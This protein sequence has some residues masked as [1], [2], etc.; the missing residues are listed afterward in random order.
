MHEPQVKKEHYDFVRY[1]HLDRWA[2]YYYQLREVLSINPKSILEVGVGDKVFGSFIK[3]NTSISYTSV[4]IAED[5]QP[6]VIGSVHKLP[7]EDNSFDAVCIFEVLEHIPFSEFELCV[8]ELFRVSKSGVFISLPHFG[9]P[10]KFSFKIPFLKEVK[11]A[12]KIPFYKKHTFNGEHYFEIGKQGYPVKLIIDK[13]SKYGKLENH[14]VPFENQYHHFF[15][16]HKT[17]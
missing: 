1:S 3:N 15:T 16:L 9:P 11:F 5:L 17:Q 13:I 12:F 2:S 7:F 8:S 10:V 4:D 14:F 6:D